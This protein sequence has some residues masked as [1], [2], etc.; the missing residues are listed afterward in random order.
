MIILTIALALR[1]IVVLFAP[2]PP[3]HPDTFIY[4]LAARNI[5]HRGTFAFPGTGPT[6]FTVP[7]YSIFVCGV[8]AVFG[9][10][11]FIAVRII[12]A[13][14]SVLIVYLVFR[15]YLEIFEK[16]TFALVA[17]GLYALYVPAFAA[18][19]YIMT[20]VL[21]TL[22]FM[23]FFLFFA[24]SFRKP[25]WKS[26]V[27]AG[28]FLGLSCLARPLPFY[29]PF[30]AA[31]I[32]FADRV[33]FRGGRRNIWENVLTNLKRY[34]A[35]YLAAFLALAPW[36]L[37]NLIVFDKFILFAT[38][39]G[40]PFLKGSYYHYDYPYEDVWMSDVN[41]IERNKIW[42]E[43]AKN[44]FR[45]ELE[46]S[47]VRY[48][49]WYLSKIPEMWTRPYLHENAHW[50]I[51]KWTT[52]QHNILVWLCWISIVYILLNSN[53]VMKLPVIYLLYHTILHVIFLGFTRY[54]FTVTPL[55]AIL[56][57]YGIY[58]VS[59]YAVFLMESRKGRGINPWV[60]YGTLALAILGFSF[61]WI[62]RNNFRQSSGI[63][64]ASFH[65]VLLSKAFGAI[66]SAAIL[67]YVFPAVF[68]LSRAG[69]LEG[70]RAR[71]GVIIFMMIFCLG[72]FFQVG[73]IGVN[74]F[75]RAVCF[76]APLRN[77]AVAEHIIDLPAW[78]KGYH[79]NRLVVQITN[80]DNE[81]IGYDLKILA[82]DG[83]MREFRRGDK[84]NS[85]TLEIPLTSETI[86]K[87]ET[88]HVKIIASGVEGGNYPKLFGTTNIFRGRSMLDGRGGDLSEDPGMQRGSYNVGVRLYGKGRMRNVYFWR[89]GRS[90]NQN[91]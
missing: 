3:I 51:M 22:A 8:Y 39:S 48:A 75:E 86:E 41:E 74:G 76:V 57:S 27:W 85:P 82:N 25:G 79:D 60:R 50:R 40:H 46:K 28:L 17:S 34:A 77:G 87:N 69:L 36:V 72:E 65:P 64:L 53:A 58:L 71:A 56:S 44:H 54:F 5:L 47:P 67:V 90:G 73:P 88:L 20:E 24:M 12:Q 6:A 4:D 49:R 70:R 78:K 89:G 62:L 19:K 42:K 29:F 38:Q 37:R 2:D 7:G 26:P 23:I 13:F 21:F 61:L 11:D 59:R 35:L 66:V 14:I 45:E 84:M 10:S 33:I 9:D 18:N 15:L 63:F 80:S 16:R 91:K 81:P 31:M 68:C 83:V 30:F 32:L 1:L 52:V 43:L 55:V